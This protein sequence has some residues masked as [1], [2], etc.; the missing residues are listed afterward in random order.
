MLLVHAISSI[1]GYF[2][3]SF[4]PFRKNLGDGFSF[5]FKKHNPGWVGGWTKKPF[6]RRLY[7]I[8]YENSSTYFIEKIKLNPK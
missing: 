3:K 8:K 6:S 1:V 2:W 5:L 7:A 4:G